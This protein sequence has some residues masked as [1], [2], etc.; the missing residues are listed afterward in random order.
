[1]AYAKL[2][3]L[4]MLVLLLQASTGTAARSPPAVST[5]K[6]DGM[7]GV[8]TVNGFERGEDGGGPSECD[9]K[10]HSDDD[11]LVALPTGLYQGGARC[12]KMIRITSASTGRSAEAMVVDECDSRKGCKDNIVD[13]SK[14]VWKALGL[15]ANADDA[16]AITWSDA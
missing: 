1:M 14:A 15:D 5:S 10:Y 9:G 3:A 2:A 16:A 11:M 13:T 8:M 4:A 6:I 12:F 7:P